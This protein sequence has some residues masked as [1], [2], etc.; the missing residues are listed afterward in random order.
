MQCSTQTLRC[1]GFHVLLCF[2]DNLRLYYLLFDSIILVPELHVK[3]C[4]HI[5]F[6][7]TGHLFV[8][9]HTRMALLDFITYGSADWRHRMQDSTAQI[10][11]VYW[12]PTR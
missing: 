2:T 9:V 6:S 10:T 1:I 12:S 11:D 4:P 8:G 3:K 7:Y 5:R